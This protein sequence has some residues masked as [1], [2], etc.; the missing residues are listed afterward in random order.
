M[1]IKQLI[2]GTM[3]VCCYIIFCEKSR[4][5]AII[6]PGGNEEDILSYCQSENLF[7]KYIIATHSHPDHICGNRIVQEATGAKIIMHQQE[8]EFFSLPEVQHYFSM[9]NLAQSPPADI[10]VTDG[11]TIKI[12]HE[13]LKVL[14]TPGHT[15]GGICLYRQGHCFTGDTLFAG[16][17]GRTD[18]PGGSLAE[19]QTSIKEKLMTLPPETIVWPGHGYGG[20]QSTIEKEASS[21]PYF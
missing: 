19:L 5:G 4:E 15:P 7:V 14:H 1:Q 8:A 17:V 6:D 13:D 21:N 11:E 3:E 16:A 2:V 20:L 12:G 10:T 9:L 18:F